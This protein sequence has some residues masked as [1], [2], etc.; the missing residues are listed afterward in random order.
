M[1]SLLPAW[2]WCGRWVSRSGQQQP[3]RTWRFQ[4]LHY[5]GCTAAAAVP[6]AN[7]N[8]PFS[9]PP[10]NSLTPT[11]HPHPNATTPTQVVDE[12]KGPITK[13]DYEYLQSPTGDGLYGSVV[14]FMGRPLPTFPISPSAN[15]TPTGY[16]PSS[17]G[18]DAT[19]SSTT[20]PSPAFPPS[21]A[22]AAA[23]GSAQQSS[24]QQQQSIE[25]EDVASSSGGGP[26]IGFDKTRPLVNQQV[27]MKNR[28]QITE[29]LSTGAR[30]CGVCVGWWCVWSGV[31]VEWSVQIECGL[32][33]GGCVGC[34]HR[35]SY[36]SQVVIMDS[37]L[38]LQ[39]ACS[40]H[41]HAAP[42]TV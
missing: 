10:T 15:A 16:G 38:W 20:A 25:D 2:C 31:C 40:R 39:K 1:N 11:P 5:V 37:S 19:A 29:S 41:W 36:R 32:L 42:P 18:S 7:Q 35:V 30:V 34:V 8:A 13:K 9:P 6:P 26:F 14:D 23:A 4:R 27:A 3:P 21:A 22:A 24:S 17:Q 12:A 33:K 28:E